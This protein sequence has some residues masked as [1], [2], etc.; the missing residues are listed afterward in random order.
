MSNSNR[1]KQGNPSDSKL[2][3]MPSAGKLPPSEDCDAYSGSYDDSPPL[4]ARQSRR[5]KTQARWICFVLAILVFVPYAQV[6]WFE[7]LLCDDNDYITTVAPV[8]AGLTWEGVK[9]AF[10]APHA[11]NWH[12]ITWLSHM[13]DCELF[14][15]NPGP[16][17]LV[18]VVF[19]MASAVIL[20]LTVRMMTGSMWRSAAVA[21]LF[22]LHPLRAESVAWVAE[23]K[24]VLSGFFWMLTLLSYAW[25]ARRPGIWRYLTVFLNLALGLLCKSM[26]V[27][28][29]FLLLLLDV[30]PLRRAVFPGVGKI[31]L[32]RAIPC[33]SQSWGRLI[34]EKLPLLAL[35]IYISREAVKAQ[36]GYGS[37]TGTDELTL[38]MRAANALVTYAAYLWDMVCPIN[39]GLFYPHPASVSQSLIEDLYM[40]A[41]VAGVILIGITVV[42]IW[43]RKTRPWLLI[44]W[45]WYLGTLVPVIGI[46]QIGAQSR[47]DRYTYLTMIGI[48]IAIV[49]SVGE[50]VVRRQVARSVVRWVAAGLGVACIVL[51]W[52][53]VSYWRTDFTLFE[54]SIAV[55]PKNYFA[56]NQLGAA[57]CEKRDPQKAEFNFAKSLEFNP[58]YDFG[59]N[60]LGVSLMERGA[61]DDARKAFEHA[62]KVNAQFVAPLRNLALLLAATGHPAE[63]AAY[64]ERVVTLQ[65]GNA[66]AQAQLASI[67]EQLGRFEEAEKR[68]QYSLSLDPFDTRATRFFGI[69]YAN[70]GRLS[71]AAKWLNQT[72]QLDPNDA[73]AWNAL[74]VVLAQQGDKAKGIACLERALM[75]S[76]QHP[77]ARGNLNTLRT[78]P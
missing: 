27:T 61:L 78:Q 11:S 19:H 26:A 41:V 14:G 34:L 20:F 74:G 7:F 49:W 65:P 55:I 52:M 16:H 6:A 45:L 76:P 4:S 3:E 37:I 63:A 12:P 21:A 53:Q 17:H 51:T 18:S 73:D 40:P 70:R 43:Q 42:V 8:K 29:P 62:V 50:I 5:A 24:D 48:A 2:G 77:Q 67:Y 25:Y 38:S 35:A 46:V 15:L 71:D 9:W 31:G 64:C 58:D 33:P 30:W 72:V 56:Y 32:R 75:I 57:Y 68:F 1:E 66:S 28:M 36:G 60:N 10:N 54:R 13:L 39:L 59:N 47:A 22:A 69:F 44:G 23:R